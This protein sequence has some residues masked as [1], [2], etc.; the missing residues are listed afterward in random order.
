MEQFFSFVGVCFILYIIGSWVYD[1]FFKEKY[2]QTKIGLYKFQ[3]FTTALTHFNK[4]GT[5][6]KVNENCIVY[7]FYL[8]NGVE[9][10]GYIEFS[11]HDY[12]EKYPPYT[13][14]NYYFRAQAKI[15]NF[16]LAKKS[17][18]Y[19]KE[20]DEDLCIQQISLLKNSIT[21]S[22]NYQLAFNQKQ[23]K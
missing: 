11:I 3:E 7:R 5:P 20:F 6:I 15:E 14:H 12:I 8:S 9:Q 4:V 23:L 19:F 16:T 21:E 17:R 1:N 18:T 13:E 10:I 2:R 22:R